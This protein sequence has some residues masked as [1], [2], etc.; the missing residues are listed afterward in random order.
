[1][2]GMT[3]AA[4]YRKAIL[5][6]MA[7][8]KAAGYQEQYDTMEANTHGVKEANL[9]WELCTSAIGFIL[10]DSSFGKKFGLHKIALEL[11]GIVDN[12]SGGQLTKEQIADI[13]LSRKKRDA[14]RRICWAMQEALQKME[15]KKTVS[16]CIPTLFYNRIS[17]ADT[18]DELNDL[19]Y[20]GIE[21]IQLSNGVVDSPEIRIFQGVVRGMERARTEERID[22]LLTAII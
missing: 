20:E 17:D 21:H 9:L 2:R 11:E 8:L 19:C 22:N 3:P 16:S 1:M 13:F 15:D 5:I 4:G 7:A 18:E 6:L 10:E 12:I 14:Y